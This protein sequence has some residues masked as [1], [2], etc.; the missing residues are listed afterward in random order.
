M[1]GTFG[2]QTAYGVTGTIS[3]AALADL[4][5]GKH[6]VYVRGLDSAG[7][8][9]VIGS[10]VFNLPKTGPQTT[11]GSVVDSPANGASDVDI[12]ATGDDSA[13]GGTITAAEYFID[14]VGTNGS[15]TS[16]GLNRTATIVSEDATLTAAAVKGLSEGVH[17]ILVHS[18]DSLGL[19]GPPLDI[20]LTVDLTGPAVDAASVGPNPS[21]GVLSNQSN[22][23]NLVISTQI[24]DKDAGGAVQSKLIAAEAFLDKTPPAVG[25][26]GLQLI[27]V[28]GKFDSTTEVAYGLIP[29]SQVKALSNGPHNVFVR[30]ED[31]AGN[32]GPAFTVILTVDKT[33]PVLG[34]PA[35]GSPSTVP[36]GALLTLS[37]PLTETVGLG[38]AE[39]WTGTVDPGVGLA[40]HVSV[41]ITGSG[42]S[43]RA[44]LTLPAPALTG[45]QKFNFR[46]QD[47]A[48]NWSNAVSATVTVTRPNAI[49]S[50]VFEGTLSA[51]SARTSATNPV[52]ATTAK[53]TTTPAIEPGTTKGMQAMVLATGTN[54]AAYVTDTK[55]L[56]ESTYHARFAFN[57]VSLNSGTTATTSLTI[58][59]GR[60]ANNNQV[61]TV[62]YRS[63]GGVPR[64]QAVLSR[65]G[66]TTATAWVPLN[67]SA[68]LQVDWL[69]AQNGSLKFTVNGAAQ[70][71]LTGNSSALLLESVRLGVTAGATNTSGSSGTAY[72]DS[73]LSTRNTM[74]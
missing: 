71:L 36:A 24:S 54:R 35:T 40:T 63:T 70:P 72:F 62:L 9:G 56:A 29:L 65:A 31:A 8:W 6:L 58:F 20:P 28:D 43:Q 3:K 23:G 33:A 18:Q 26:T 57:G 22:P 59:E 74:P 16:L 52:T 66:G 21:N 42:A 13:A 50:D 48:G 30:G 67:G 55:P 4:P 73:F 69:S 41:S 45:S 7:N 1:T 46:V 51:W 44:V 15:G 10:A 53:L 5:A 14:T 61:F 11:N 19:W 27:A 39:F 34:T 47:T 25:G 37:A 32:W 68:L 38:T 12:S 60:T 64:V 17:H 49:F 2:A